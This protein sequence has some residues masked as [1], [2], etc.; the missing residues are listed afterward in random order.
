MKRPLE[1]VELKLV[2]VGCTHGNHQDVVWPVGDILIHTGDVQKPTEWNER[3]VNQAMLES[4]HTEWSEFSVFLAQLRQVYGYK[5]I[6]VVGGNHDWYASERPLEVKKL[7]WKAT[8]S[9]NSSPGGIYYLQ[10]ELFL[11]PG[12]NAC[13]SILIFG[14]PLSFC[15]GRYSFAF[16]AQRKEKHIRQ[17]EFTGCPNV[18]EVISSKFVPPET[19]VD[20]L[21]THGPPFGIGDSRIQQNN[22]V[23]GSKELLG[24]VIKLSPKYHFFSDWHGDTESGTHG[25]GHHQVHG[26]DFVNSA[27][28]VNNTHNKRGKCIARHPIVLNWIF[29][30]NPDSAPESDPRFEAYSKWK[31]TF[32]PSLLYPSFTKFAGCVNCENTLSSTSDNDR[33]PVHKENYC[34]KSWLDLLEEVERR[35]GTDVLVNLQ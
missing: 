35:H 12:S 26:I 24:Y 6:F 11:I 8:L 3:M 17:L 30:T 33:P 23:T 21:I 27:L 25:Y 9:S 18:S 15:R 10:D 28:S 7:F 22:F 29:H 31:E 19:P 2:V 4:A 13:H 34:P 14:S 1:Q 32:N 16:Q 20:I 5:W